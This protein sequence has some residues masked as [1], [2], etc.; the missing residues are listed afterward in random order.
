MLSEEEIEQKIYDEIIVDCYD[1]LE[2]SAGWYNY[3]EEN[4]LFPFKATAQLKKRAG[5]TELQEV[6]ILGLAS[7]PEDFTGKDFNLQMQSGDYI[8]PV[9]YSQLSNLRASPE[10]LEAF[11]VW[12]YWVRK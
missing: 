3:L 9:A 2:A 11:T 5:S 6:E 12:D 4:L 7:R 10:T 8:F 1:E